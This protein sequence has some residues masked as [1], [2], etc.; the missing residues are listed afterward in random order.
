MKFLITAL[1]A[2]T[3]TGCA[4]FDMNPLVDVANSALDEPTIKSGMTSREAAYMAT[5]KAYAK[6]TGRDKPIVDIEG[7]G[8]EIK[9]SGIKSIKVYGPSH[10]LQAPTAPKS[11][12]VEIMDSAGKMLERVF[13]PWVAITEGH[14]TT[15]EA[16]RNA[17]E[18]DR[19]QSSER[20]AITVEAIRK[21]P[22][23]VSE[24]EVVYPRKPE[25]VVAVPA[26]VVPQ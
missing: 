6:E 11:A 3:L 19:I 8:S 2:V 23:V 10:G 21:E 17:L 20:Q 24:G 12:L 5:Y 4:G 1:L 22:L 16:G 9:I 7:D 14:Q 18:S 26:P 13:I 15:R 25:P